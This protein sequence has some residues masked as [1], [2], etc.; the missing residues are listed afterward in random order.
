MSKNKKV[1]G[2]S[3]HRHTLQNKIDHY[4]KIVTRLTNLSTKTPMVCKNLNH[5]QNKIL[6]LQTQ[7]QEA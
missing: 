3:N 7:A 1:S 5:Y 6:E 2:Y 4:Q